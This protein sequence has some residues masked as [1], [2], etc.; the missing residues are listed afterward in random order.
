MVIFEKGTDG[1]GG[2]VRIL[3][4]EAG[5][6]REPPPSLGGYAV[7][8]LCHLCD[9]IPFDALL[10]CPGLSQAV[11]PAGK[12]VAAP[13]S[14]RRF[15]KDI[16]DINRDL[17]FR[18]LAYVGAQLLS[19]LGG[20]LHRGRGLRHAWFARGARGRGAERASAAAAA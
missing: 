14:H 6:M 10:G 8:F 2:G 12:N 5:E 11:G 9:G 20:L 18:D 16:G 4:E 3:Q 1:E 13:P 15:Q 19:G 7:G 17:A